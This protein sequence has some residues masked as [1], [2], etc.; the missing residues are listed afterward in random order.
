MKERTQPNQD[1]QQDREQ[2]DKVGEVKHEALI[3]SDLVNLA[4]SYIDTHKNKVENSKKPLFHLSP[5]IGWMNDPNGFSEFNRNYN[6]F[7]QYY[8]YDAVWGSMHWGHQ[9][10][11]DFIKWEHQSVALAPDK[12]YDRDG[13]FSGTAIT[14]GDKHYLVYTSVANGK[15]NQSMAYSYDGINYQKVE[16]NPILS[17]KHLPE[18]FSNADFR[19]PKIFKK[20]DKYFILCGNADN[21][22]NKQVICFASDSIMGSLNTLEL[23]YPDKLLEAF[24]S[25]QTS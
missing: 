7:Y 14:F 21:K 16:K 13:C 6:L 15:Q 1:I 4:N 25:A 2:K 10:T 8:P 3:P 20:G 9:T 18:G 24:L 22:G 5:I 17:G 12:N 23:H 11:K 19:D